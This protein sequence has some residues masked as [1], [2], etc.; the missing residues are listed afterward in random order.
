MKW[1]GGKKYPEKL[2]NNRHLQLMIYG[3][4]LQQDT[5]KWPRYAYY[6]LEAAKMLTHDRD[7]FARAQASAPQE[8]Q[9]LPQLWARFEKTWDWRNA[10]LR[11]GRIALVFDDIEHDDVQTDGL[12]AIEAMSPPDR[13]STRL[14]SS[15]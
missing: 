14:N 5:G 2:A 13:K 15:N 7:A 6:L 12:L 10:Q 9:T 1:S 11:E 3:G 4:L 8:L